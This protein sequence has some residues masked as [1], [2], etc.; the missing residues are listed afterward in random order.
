MTVEVINAD[1]LESAVE[2]A[3]EGKAA[4]T[5]E[6]A[7]DLATEIVETAEKMAGD[8]SRIIDALNARFEDMH[9]KLEMIE[10]KI[11][12]LF[13]ILALL[14][15]AILKLD[16]LEKEVVEE[17]AEI[18]EPE[19]APAV[20]VEGDLEV[21]PEETVEVSEPKKREEKITKRKWI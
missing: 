11:D 16:D 15:A 4:E 13:D 5:L 1:A 19:P 10:G 6:A 14:D 9:A 20:V 17:V 3:V 7:A 8:D 12:G 18:V 2:G 21:I